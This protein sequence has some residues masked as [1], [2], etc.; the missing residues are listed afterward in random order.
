MIHK[1]EEK[2]RTAP[3]KNNHFS[4]NNNKI[5]LDIHDQKNLDESNR[6]NDFDALI[7]NGNK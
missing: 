1:L 6:L 4:S 5:I 7:L 3:I 2:K